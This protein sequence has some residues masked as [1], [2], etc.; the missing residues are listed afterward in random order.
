[1]QN[2]IKVTSFFGSLLIIDILGGFFALGVSRVG[3]PK[4]KRALGDD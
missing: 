1:V 4:R 2:F 3:S